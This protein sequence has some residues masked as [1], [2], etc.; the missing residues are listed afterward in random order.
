MAKKKA[1]LIILLAIWGSLFSY[2]ILFSEG[3]RTAPLKYTKGAIS[4]SATKGG[5]DASIQI[6]TDLLQPAP[7]TSPEDVRNIFAPLPSPKPPPPPPP[8]P[9]PPTLP[10]PPVIQPPTPEE[11]A[12]A[13][14]RSDLAEFKYIGFLDRGKGRQEGFISMKQETIIATRGEVVFG[15]FIVK[16]LSSSLALIQEQNTHAEV[17]LHLSDERK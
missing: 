2:R 11:L 13:Q 15:H 10:P 16:E 5:E 9:L 6:R 1:T 8:R 3:P 14:A 17:T 12:L 4:S 7:S